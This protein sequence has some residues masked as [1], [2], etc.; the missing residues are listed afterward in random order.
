[1]NHLMMP[2]YLVD[3]RLTELEMARDDLLFELHKQ[4]THSPTDKHVSDDSSNLVLLIEAYWC[5]RIS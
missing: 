3:R 2:A 5:R 4:D 1:M